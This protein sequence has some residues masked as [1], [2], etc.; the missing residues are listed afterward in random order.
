MSECPFLGYGKEKDLATLRRAV[1]GFFK[2][3]ACPHWHGDLGGGWKE[4][5]KRSSGP[6]HSRRGKEEKSNHVA[7]ES[8]HMFPPFTPKRQTK[9]TPSNKQNRWF[10]KFFVFPEGAIFRP[11]MVE[12]S[13]EFARKHNLPLLNVRA[14]V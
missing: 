4:A 7:N 13:H 5:A 3:Y 2:R 1:T 10:S 11:C 12:K 8:L 6:S 14:C 9:P